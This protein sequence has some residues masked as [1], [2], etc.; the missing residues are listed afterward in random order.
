MKYMQDLSL[1]EI[2]ILTGQSKNTIAVQLHRGL[3][4][5]KI[6]YKHT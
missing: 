3:E 4:K 2:S 1:K 6:L 5:L